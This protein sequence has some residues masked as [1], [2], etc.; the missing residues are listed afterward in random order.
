MKKPSCRRTISVA[1]FRIVR[2]RCSRLLVSQLAFCRLVARK[3]RSASLG[4][5]ALDA[6]GV[7]LIDQHAR[8][9]L[10]VEFDAPGIV[11]RPAKRTRRRSPTGSGGAPKARPGLGSRRRISAT[12]SARSSSSTPQI[13][14]RLAIIAPGEQRQIGDQRLHRRIVAVALDQLQRQA[15]GEIAREHAGRLKLSAGAPAPPRR[16]RAGRRAGS[17][18]SSSD[19]VR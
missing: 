6:G 13:R 1:T 2:A 19:P 9:R 11:G 15:F 12:M 16:A 4:A 14:R 10:A 18:S 3:S 7:G 5:A 17:A 8:Q